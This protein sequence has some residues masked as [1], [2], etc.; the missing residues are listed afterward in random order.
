M[1]TSAVPKPGAK[2]DRLANRTDYWNDFALVR[3]SPITDG[4]FVTLRP[5]LNFH[6][7]IQRWRFLATSDLL[8]GTGGDAPALQ[9]ARTSV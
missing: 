2:I 3:V 9:Q 7:L 4:N 6:V 5:S 8:E 1:V